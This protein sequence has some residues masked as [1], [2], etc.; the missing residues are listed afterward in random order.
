MIVVA[1]VTAWSFY[2][3]KPVAGWLFV[4]YLAWLAFANYLNG[5]IVKLNPEA[6]PLAFALST[7][8]PAPVEVKM[9]GSFTGPQ[10][11]ASAFLCTAQM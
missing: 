8:A 9:L 7:C 10:N 5:V 11:L 2:K 1:G 6:C 4:P 3:V